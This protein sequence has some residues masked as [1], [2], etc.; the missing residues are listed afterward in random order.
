NVEEIALQFF[1]DEHEL[2][3]I[4][5]VLAGANDII[6]EWVSDDATFRESIRELT[7]KH[8]TVQS[9]LKESE[10]DEKEIYKMYYEYS[11]AVRTLV[12]HRILAINRG[13]KEDV[14]RVNI[15]APDDRI[16]TYLGK[17]VIPEVK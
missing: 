8:G 17:Q 3:T 6:A 1:S 10:K 13:E 12:S 16:T 7:W 4:E 5:D 11:E 14:L 9:E 15:E 2:A